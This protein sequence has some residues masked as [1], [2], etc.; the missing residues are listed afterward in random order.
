MSTTPTTVPGDRLEPEALH[1]VIAVG[2][3]SADCGRRELEW[4]AAEAALRN[5][6]LHVLRTFHLREQTLPWQSSADRFLT[7]ELE[8]GAR[9]AM[10]VAESRARTLY[11][12]LDVRTSVVDGLVEE[13]LASAAQ[14]AH[15]LVVGARP[16]S[17]YAATVVGRVS[18][19]VAARSIGP[20][21]VVRP[22]PEA[23]PRAEPGV[24]V[25]V[26]GSRSMPDVLAFA[27]DH[28]SAHG[29]PLRAVTCWRPDGY[30]MEEAM[31]TGLPDDLAEAWLAEAVAGWG[32]KYPD[33]RV[34]RSLVIERPS[35]GLVQ[36]S[37]GEALLV[38]GGGPRHPRLGRML[39]SATQAAL[40]HADC[41]V[42]VVHGR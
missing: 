36:A 32:D 35:L 23:T 13:V 14:H 34:E 27:F 20:V 1:G 37:R 5:R 7:R 12:Q 19:L 4:A 29:L 15:L 24:V 6:P 21:V 2:I 39:G 41:P 3:G 10:R 22:A 26:D 30:L 16:M 18:A 28:A 9:R 40:H 31:S 33:V 11:P 17:S 25:G 42:A 38:V 8:R